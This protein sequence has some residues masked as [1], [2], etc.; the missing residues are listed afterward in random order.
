MSGWASTFRDRLVGSRFVRNVGRLWA[1]QGVA[2]A[3][4]AIQGVL[5]ARW[6]G[7]SLF[8]TAALVI[9]VPSVVATIFDARAAD[10][11]IRYL[12]EFSA[13]NDSRRASAFAKLGYLLDVGASSAALVVVVVIAP[14]AASHI[15]HA[16]VAGL[17]VLAAAALVLRAPAVTSEAI[18]VT[19]ERYPTLA[20]VQVTTAVMK[21]LAAVALVGLGYGI[22]GMVVG[23]AMGSIAEGVVMTIVAT[24]A[25]R[26]AWRTSWWSSSLTS[27]GD[28]RGEIARFV[29]WTDLSSLLGVATKQMDV[30]IVGSFAGTA[31]AGFYRL[32]VSLGQL[33]GFV[34]GP[35]QSI[36]Y[37]RFSR[38][39]VG[40]PR[41]LHDEAAR[42]ATH[43]SVPLAALGLLAI[44]LTPWAVR[45][46][47][48]AA[49]AP[50][51]TLAQIMVLLEAVWF[52]F[53]WVRPLV[54]TLGEV[55]LWTVSNLA[56]AALSLAG[57]LVIVP[58]AGPAGA[59]W[60]R[61][62]TST[63]AQVLPL[64]VVLTRYERGR[65]ESTSGVKAIRPMAEVTGD[66][67]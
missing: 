38:V 44:P 28:R 48:G 15:A 6:L 39:G 26:S 43:V 17:M 64:A 52:A 42:A 12:G 29:V 19:L 57:Y 50:A 16:D 18:L 63:F 3:A 51:G 35:V 22:G 47:A 60:V 41:E 8:G 53:L 40:R 34:A 67:R 20:R 59:A 9:A 37:Q 46:I 24:R 54:F 31:A 36:L 5:V 11:A 65:Y 27:L 13:A 1:A 7:P 56:V 21:A 66:R 2:L 49:Y 32:A 4:G 14:W 23:W 45:T 55:R 25:G 10:A 61:F 58:A 62:A 33:G 30:I